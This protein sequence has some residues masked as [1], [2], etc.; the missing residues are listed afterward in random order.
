MQDCHHI[1]WETIQKRFF[2]EYNLLSEVLA[3][4]A[5]DRTEE[6]CVQDW[7]HCILS[8][9]LMCAYSPCAHLRIHKSDQWF[10]LLF[11]V[12]ILLITARDHMATGN[13]PFSSSHLSTEDKLFLA[14][15]SI[16]RKVF[17]VHMT[18]FMW[19]SQTGDMCWPFQNKCT[20][21][22]HQSDTCHRIN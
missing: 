16:M 22:F 1:C 21:S 5:N 7:L 9:S 8:N 17:L 19:L 11:E 6:H 10:S 18:F 14:W 2:L 4:N 12:S 20:K 3:L 15:N 13:V